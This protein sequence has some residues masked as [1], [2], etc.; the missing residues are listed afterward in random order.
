MIIFILILCI[1]TAASG[2]KW[3]K[4]RNSSKKSGKKRQKLSAS[5]K[6]LWPEWPNDQYKHVFNV[7]SAHYI[8]RSKVPRW[9]KIREFLG[10]FFQIS[11]S[12][13]VKRSVTLSQT[14]KS[15]TSCH[16]LKVKY[17]CWIL[18]RI[19]NFAKIWFSTFGSGI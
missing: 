19:E 9:L 14:Q 3:A 6:F 4:A 12:C 7:N 5:E 10:I 8:P 2:E 16:I 18:K 17:D 1:N 11:A 13:T 15:D